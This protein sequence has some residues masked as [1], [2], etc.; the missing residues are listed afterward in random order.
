MPGNLAEFADCVA[1]DRS[2]AIPDVQ[3]ETEAKRLALSDA[4]QPYDLANA[5]LMRATLVKLAEDHHVFILNFH[6]I[7]AD[8]SSLPI[9]TKNSLC[10]MRRAGQQNGSLPRLPV[11][12]ADY[13]AWQ[14]EWLKSSA[15]DKQIGYWKK[16]LDSLPE[17]CELPTDYDRLTI[18]TYNGARLP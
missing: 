1:S 13:A 17:P 8:G 16:Q 11:Q 18:P 6:H 7:V 3:A 2:Y 4:R 14:H 15:F 12:Y 5:P 9:F 10:F